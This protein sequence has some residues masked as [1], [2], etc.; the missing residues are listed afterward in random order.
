M[1]I[2]LFLHIL[3]KIFNRNVPRLL[4]MAGL[5][6]M[7]QTVQAGGSNLSLSPND[8]SPVSAS[9]SGLSYSPENHPKNIKDFFLYGDF[10]YKNNIQTVLF[11]KKGFE[12][13]P[14][15]IRLHA[16]EQLILRFDDLDGGFRN[17][18]YTIVHCDADWQ[19]SM[20]DPYEYID[21]FYEDQINNYRHS[22]NTR[23][24]YTHYWLEFPARHLR[25]RLSGNY[26]LKIFQDGDPEN[27]VLT[28]RFMIFEP[29]LHIDAH[30]RQAN[31][32]VHR[33]SQQQLSFTVNTAG[34]Y[35]SNP[36][37]EIQV[38]VTQN[39]R[40]DN[41]IAGLP[42][43]SIHGNSLIYDYEER[44]LFEGGNEFRRFDIR[45]L[46]YTSDRIAE[47]SSSR[48]HTEVFL[49]PDLRRQHRRY[50][51]VDDIN[52]RFSIKTHDAPDDNTEGD[53]AWVHFS[54]PLDAPMAYGNIYLLG[55]M[56]QWHL[57]EHT[58]LT[59]NYNTKQYTI[60]LLLKQGYYNYQYAFREAGET[61]GSLTPIEGSHSETENDY[62]IYV[63]YRQPGLRYD[64]LI[65]V[66]QLNSALSR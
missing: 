3:I 48:T 53:Y 39:G 14:P 44:M 12:L 52:G 64:Q 37:Q 41:A 51:F 58:Q 19:P 55:S 61:A 59:Y 2:K 27:V 36:Y 18:S 31:L 33:D 32:V 26:L 6:I 50:S 63:Y 25:P 29:K 34:L 1:P 38:V 7:Q 11:H 57:A 24:P 49:I 45:S 62:T 60:S 43:R 66:T 23:M 13:S 47:L 5:I 28:R 65:G 4:I 35:V 56:T 20:L 10:I 46:R 15:L 22:V 42:P 8:G 17:Y 21:G 40:W 16:N 30:V 54:L 9:Q